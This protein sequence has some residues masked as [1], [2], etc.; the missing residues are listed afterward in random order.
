MK[1]SVYYFFLLWKTLEIEF[2]SMKTENTGIFQSIC[3]VLS[4][5]FNIHIK[6]RRMIFVQYR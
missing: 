1:A 2:E 4:I 5:T 6:K 3:R